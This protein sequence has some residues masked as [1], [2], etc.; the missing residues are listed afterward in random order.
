MSTKPMEPTAAWQLEADSAEA[1]ERYLVPAVMARWAEALVERA[2]L[3]PGG[4]VLDVGCGTGTVARTAAARLGKDGRLTGIDLNE[5]MLVRARMVSSGVRPS[6]EWRQG[7]ATALPFPD[8]AFDVV[9]SQQMLQFVPD[10]GA[11]LR[12]MRRVLDSGGRAAVAVCRPIERSPGYP[13][14]AEALRRHVGPEAEAICA[15]PSPRGRSTT[16]IDS[17]REAAFER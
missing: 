12:E 14:L 17:S 4:R 13:P 11:A 16:C 1:Y 15:R 3:R 6:I 5:G 9:L 7:N 8:G 10:R 2:A